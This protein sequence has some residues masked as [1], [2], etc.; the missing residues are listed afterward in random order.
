MEIESLIED[1]K[2]EYWRKRIKNSVQNI[3]HLYKLKESDIKVFRAGVEPKDIW[4]VAVDECNP[5]EAERLM[6]V[7]YS[8][9]L[10]S[11]ITLIQ[12]K[13][14]KVIFIGSN[15]SLVFVLK[16]QVPDCIVVKLP[17]DIKEPKMVSEAKINLEEILKSDKTGK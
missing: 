1:V 17:D 2:D 8:K 14:K 6:R 4:I 5:K 10:P 16:N 12:Y 11:P 9:K 15:R 3:L 13:N 7:R